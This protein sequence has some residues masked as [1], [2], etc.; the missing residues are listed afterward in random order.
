MRIFFKPAVILMDRLRFRRKMTVIALVIS[1]PVMSFMYLL[2]TE[3]N[4]DIQFAGREKL[5]AAYIEAVMKFVRDVQQHRGMSSAFLNGDALFR[6]KMLEKQSHIDNDIKAVFELDRKY[7]SEIPITDEWKTISENWR[8]LG[9]RAFDLSAKDSFAGHTSFIDSVLSLMVRLADISNL[10]LAPTIE[11]YYLMDTAVTKLPQAA[12]YTGQIRGIGAAVI[13]SR[14]ISPETRARLIILSGLC[15]AA[16]EKVNSNMQ[17]VFQEA[18]DMIALTGDRLRESDLMVYDALNMLDSRVINES[19]IN[20]SPSEYF[21]AFSRGGDAILKLHEAVTS[22]LNIALEKR[23]AGLTR[24][25]NLIELSAAFSFLIAF[26][27]FAGNYLSVTDSLSGLTQASKRIGGGDMKVKVSLK[28]RDEMQELAESFN[29]MSKKLSQV[30]GELKRSNTELEHFAYLASHDL[31]SPLLAI[32]SNLRLFQRRY[33]GKL[34]AEADLF[35]SDAIKSTL[36][37]ERLI[38]DL[39]TYS[40][41]GTRGT[42]FEPTDCSEALNV[43]VANLKVAIEDSGAV[44]TRD[45][46]PEVKADSIQIVQLFQNLIGNA[47]RFRGDAPPLIHVS[48]EL[49]GSE[50]VFSVRD[51]GV[52]IPPEQTE[53]IFEIFHRAHGEKFEG[54]GMGLAICKKIAERHGG[55]IWVESEPGKGSTFYFTV[56]VV[57]KREG[58][59]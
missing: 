51:N 19:G 1:L 37:M 3:I 35:I 24:K 39:L 48:A 56:P 49:R 47:V 4:T 42:P 17:K 45:A 40:R 27:L 55:R 26:Y 8:A 44:I 2:L 10:T 43:A 34:D 53:K 25:R 18:P 52:G 7:S 32:G 50:W 41:V 54:T 28:A 57:G 16:V 12:E 38:S 33:R 9:N 14:E 29:D 13:V 11:S 21:A 5:G 30:M 31:K 22:A 23:I 6:A 46:L 20:I 15:R 59:F 36:R 58:E